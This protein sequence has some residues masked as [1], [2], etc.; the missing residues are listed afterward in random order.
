MTLLETL[1]EKGLK[2]FNE[3][4]KNTPIADIQEEH[5]SYKINTNS[6][7]EVS[8]FEEI[9]CKENNNYDKI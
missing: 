3:M 8:I 7:G 2:N 4:L 5:N 6:E 1:G 9:S